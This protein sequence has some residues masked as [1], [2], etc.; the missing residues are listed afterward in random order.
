MKLTDQNELS[1]Q[2]EAAREAHRAR[3]IITAVVDGNEYDVGET[4]IGPGSD[5]ETTRA[6]LMRSVG[7]RLRRLSLTERQIAA[8]IITIVEAPL[9]Y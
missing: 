4:M 3:Y 9:L 5:V 1:L 2:L 8:A 6:A 7:E